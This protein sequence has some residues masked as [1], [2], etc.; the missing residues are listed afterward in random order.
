MDTN[1]VIGFLA[2]TL[3][4]LSNERILAIVNSGEGNLSVV[5]QIELLSHNGPA[6]EMQTIRDFV[7][8]SRLIPLT[9]AIVEQ[10]ISLRKQ[11]KMKVPDAIIAATAITEGL[12]LFTR[13]TKDFDHIKGLQV[14]N[15]YI[16][17]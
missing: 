15:P 17:K 4:I 12:V 16:M 6:V 8:F 5:N 7:A 13:N 3:P 1:I 2:G 9:E 14:M 10:T 11:H